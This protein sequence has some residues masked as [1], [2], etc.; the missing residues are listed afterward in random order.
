MSEPDRKG[1]KD[2]QHLAKNLWMPSVGKFL[3]WAKEPKSPEA[4]RRRSGRNQD[5]G[6]SWFVFSAAQFLGEDFGT[7][8]FANPH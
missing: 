2:I 8:I 1:T 6:E 3:F 7:L 5:W 4:G